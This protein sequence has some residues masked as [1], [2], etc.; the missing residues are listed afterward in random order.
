D[1]QPVVRLVHPALAGPVRVPALL[2][3]LPGGQGDHPG[4]DGPRGQRRPAGARTDRSPVRAVGH[5]RRG[6][7]GARAGDHV[8]APTDLVGRAAPGL[9]GRDRRAVRLRRARRAGHRERSVVGPGSRQ[10]QWHLRQRPRG[11]G[12]DRRETG[13]YRT[14][15]PRQTAVRAL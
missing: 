6:R 1:R 8:S 9:H 12:T 7:V 10:Y 13:R 2:L 15:W 11:A 4:A 3:P 14:I 5:R